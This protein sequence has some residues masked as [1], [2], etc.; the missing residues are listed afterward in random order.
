[1]RLIAAQKITDTVARL[2]VKANI[3]LRPDVLSALRRARSLET[4]ARAK[5]IL[6]AIIDNAAIARRK[7]L[8]VCQD[9]GLPC[10]YIELGRDVRVRGDLNRAVNQGIEKGYRLAYL[11]NSVVRDPLG[12]GT[13]GYSPGI[14][15]IDLVKGGRIKI[16]VLPKGF[17][18][19]NKSRLM[20]FNPTAGMDDIKRFIVDTVRT[21]G[22]DACPP[23]VVG[24]GIG[25]TADL[26]CLLAKKALLRNIGAHHSSRLEEDILAAVNRLNIGPMGLGGRTTALAV[27]IETHPTHIAGLPVSVN[28][29]CHATRS[30]TATI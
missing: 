19:E 1:M 18:C 30:A 20:M 4:T 13:S 27:R 17:G 16:T 25:G 28:I 7:K 15:H 14:V 9:T 23:Y 8:A 24:V 5:S 10:V 3:E 29:S 22:P 26:A 2:C 21:A 11:R 6:K 12:R